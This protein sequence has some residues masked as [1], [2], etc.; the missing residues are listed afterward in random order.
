[1]PHPDYFGDPVPPAI[2]LADYFHRTYPVTAQEAV[3]NWRRDHPTLV[4]V[5]NESVPLD[6][7]AAR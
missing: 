6:A 4:H 7:Y 2:S 5:W 1:M 3:S